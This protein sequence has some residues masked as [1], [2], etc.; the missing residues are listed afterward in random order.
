M[1]TAPVLSDH[2][3][4]CLK[5]GTRT[6]THAGAFGEKQNRSTEGEEEKQ[7]GDSAATG[8]YVVIYIHR[9]IDI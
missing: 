9:N 5:G 4:Q 6:S 1:V 2:F 8:K 7:L 3:D